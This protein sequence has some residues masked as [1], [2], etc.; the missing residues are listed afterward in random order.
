MNPNP[1]RQKTNRVTFKQSTEHVSWRPN[2]TGLRQ[3][4]REAYQFI[5]EFLGEEEMSEFDKL[6]F[7]RAVDTLSG[8]VR[9][10]VDKTMDDYLPKTA[11]A[12]KIE[13]LI[14]EEASEVLTSSVRQQAML[15]VVALSQVAPPFYVAQK[16]DLV[17]AGISRMFSLPLITP[18]QDRK[19]SASLY[20][21]TVQALDDM[22]QALVMDG[23]E[24]NMDMLQRILET[25]LPWLTMSEKEQEQTRAAR[26]IS[27]MLRFICNFPEV[28]HMA[29]FTISGRLMGTLGL[30]CMNPNPDVSTGALE[31]LHYLFKVLVLHRSVK[32]ETEGILRTL[33]K[34]FRG[35]WLVYIQD[36]TMFFRKFLTPGERADVI[37]VLMDAMASAGEDDARAASKV[38]RMI[39]KSPELEIGK[40]PEIVRYICYNMNSIT[41]ASAQEVM[42][43]LLQVLAQVYTDDVILTLFKMQDQSQSGVRRPWEFLALFP[44]SYEVIMEHLLQKLMHLR[45]GDPEPS[46]GTRISTLI[47][48]RAIHELL[49][50]PCGRTEVQTMFSPLFM[51]L[52]FQVSFLV[53]EGDAQPAQDQPASRWMDPVST[54]LMALKTLLCSAGYGDHVSY[55]Q[56][57]GGWELLT[58]PENHYTGVTLLAR[59][60]VIK[61][62]WH[63]RPV[64]N[65]IIS[66]LQGPDHGNH[67]TALAFMAE[68]LR[69]PDVA[70]TVDDA[71]VLVLATWFQREEPAA[72]KLLLRVVET[73]VLHGNMTRQLCLLQ[74]YVLHCCHSLDQGIVTETFLVL[75]N[76]VGHLSW[77]RSSSLLVQV[78]FT[79]R[80]FFE[81][82]SEHLRLMA[83]EIYG[84]LLA[85]VKRG[86]LV[87]PL[88]HQVF[89]LLVLLVLHLLDR[90]ISVAQ[91]CRMTLC[92]TATI[93][94][95]SKLK[96]VFADRD[97]WTIL[98]VLL[99]KQAGRAL[100]FLQQ[101]VTLFKSAQAPIRQAAVWFAGQIIQSLDVDEAGEVEEVYTALRSMSGDPDP[102]VSC[103][104]T[105]TMHV[106]EAKENLPVGTPTCFCSR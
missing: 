70:A 56:R 32:Q 104:A 102:M 39:L 27:H 73:F 89:S 65:F 18:S 25:L 55:V 63:S 37:M 1:N 12:K 66:L 81:E 54:T 5:L 88:R 35:E 2:L 47:A 62:C 42:R 69:C 77:P 86:L 103:L 100:W 10:Q 105:Q 76:V 46:E 43:K 29:K 30:F 14:L 9:A 49:L 68:L 64:F 48:T 44:Q 22:L 6:T 94:G 60:M 97:V 101:C 21:Q 52:L 67:L 75:K 31:G 79:L 83:F 82:E 19:D 11:L 23:L 106:V 33:Q 16:L 96:A 53:L 28:L 87:F 91:I 20:S 85:K 99:E 58:S 24:P 3:S 13:T 92:H 51:A 15:C 80:P 93:L 38:L 78:A 84:T 57:L 26:T 90:N 50:A 95:W 4:E 45:P 98:R 36:L 8:A 17:N 59:A 7:L 72:V 71:T 61:N 41:E 34:H 74:P 40:V